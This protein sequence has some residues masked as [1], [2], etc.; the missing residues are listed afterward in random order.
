[1][2]N[3]GGIFGM[4]GGAMGLLQAYTYYFHGSILAPTLAACALCC[5][6]LGVAVLS[7][8]GRIAG[9]LMIMPATAGTILMIL[10]AADDTILSVGMMALAILGAGLAIS[11]GRYKSAI[12][13]P[14]AL[15]E[16]LE[17]EVQQRYKSPN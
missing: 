17:E 2:K 9:I 11:H 10:P 14:D 3:T 12:E 4:L 7:T 16:R 5:I 13:D 15:R 6:C 1:M 8:G